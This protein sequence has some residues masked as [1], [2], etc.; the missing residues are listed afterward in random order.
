[1]RFMKSLLVWH[2]LSVNKKS[3]KQYFQFCLKWKTN[4]DLLSVV[5]YYHKFSVVMYDKAWQMHN[6]DIFVKTDFLVR[7][8][9]LDILHLLLNWS[10]E[11]KI[12]NNKI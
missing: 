5:L 11:K 8:L 10:Y 4:T 7:G 3:W 12:Q 9:K 1:M 6:K 2:L